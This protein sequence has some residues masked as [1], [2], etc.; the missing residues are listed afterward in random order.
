M[1]EVDICLYGVKCTVP[2]LVVP[3]QK[4]DIIIGINVFNVVTHQMKGS[5]DYWNLILRDAQGS[6]ECEQF[7]EMMSSLTRFRGKNVSDKVGTVKLTQA[8]T[9]FPKQKHLVWGQLPSHVPM[10]P[11][12]TAQYW[13][14]LPLRGRS[15]GAF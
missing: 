6:S 5:N 7:L 11:G 2:V 10:S 4:D 13:W 3:G 9:L 15:H 12:S 1:Y 8:V 14:S